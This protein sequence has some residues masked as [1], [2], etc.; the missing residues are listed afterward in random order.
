MSKNSVNLQDSFLNQVRRDGRQIAVVL[1]NGRELEGR[2]L[3]FDNFT[4]AL[5]AD[6]NKQLIYKHAIAQLIARRAP[7][8]HDEELTA[9]FED[10]DSPEPHGRAA[11]P[12]SERKPHVGDKGSASGFN[13]LDL[14]G[15][16]ISSPEGQ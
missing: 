5:L 12:A 9:P 1:T 14:S 8:G 16:K 2:V 3:G 4:V 6:Q 15:V 11:E 13:P 7:S 10:V